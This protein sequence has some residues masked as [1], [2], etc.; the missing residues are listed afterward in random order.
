MGNFPGNDDAIA[1]AGSFVYTPWTT[2]VNTYRC[3]SD[4]IVM[5]GNAQTNY[6]FCYG[7]ASRLVGGNW[8]GPTLD[9]SFPEDKGSKRG[10]FTRRKQFGFNDILD[11]TSNTIAMGEIGVGGAGDL[12]IAAHTT[13]GTL[14]SGSPVL[15][16]RAC[17]TGT[18]VNPARPRFYAPGT[19]VVLRGRRWS[20][21]HYSFTGFQTI[22]P[23]NSASCRDDASTTHY[24]GVISTA[25]YHQGG[26]HVLMAD[27]AVK[28][29]TDSI[30]SGN[31]ELGSVTVDFASSATYLPP[32]SPSPYG[33][34]GRL[35]SRAAKETVALDF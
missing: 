23:P 13:V 30:E 32:G 35:G 31:A 26:V 21:G 3:P 19:A 34:W 2:V 25:S 9:P 33:L 11:G 27:G 16:A 18:H 14:A 10:V 24:S 22:L 15:V 12:S 17:R 20:D 7:D 1:V 4:P 5:P 29:V 6:A 28:F 8:E